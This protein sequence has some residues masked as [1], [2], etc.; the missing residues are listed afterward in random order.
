M[1]RLWVL[2]VCCV[3]LLGCSREDSGIDDALSLRQNLLNCKT[4]SFDCTVTADY[5]ERIVTF[6]ME[7]N[8]E[9]SGCIRFSVTEPES[10]S[11]ISGYIEENG[12]KLTF[13]DQVLLFPMLADGYI[14][15][16]CAPFLMLQCL[17]GGY[18]HSVAKVEEGSFT[19]YHDSFAGEPLQ[20]DLWTDK[21]NNPISA[22]ILWEGRRILTLDVRNFSC[23]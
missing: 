8:I 13:D 17:K 21:A 7:C 3:F 9:D 20:L 16:V 22:E 1:K 5:A 18:I 23:V 10:I 2:L 15:P 4:C 12:A 6:T 11:G 19:I 14:S